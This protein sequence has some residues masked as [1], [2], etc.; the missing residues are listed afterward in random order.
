MVINI[1]WFPWNVMIISES[2][3]VLLKVNG[4]FTGINIK[5]LQRGLWC[6]W[7]STYNA[8][9]TKGVYWPA[10]GQTCY[11]DL[12]DL[13][14]HCLFENVM[15]SQGLKYNAEI[16][17]HALV[18][19][20]SFCK[21]GYFTRVNKQCWSSSMNLWHHCIF[22]NKSISQGLT[23]N[24]EAPQNDFMI[25]L[26]A[27]MVISQG[28]TYNAEAPPTWICWHAGVCPTQYCLGQQRE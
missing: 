14:Y 28:L 19:P 18:I 1:Q 12:Y 2:V 24:A 27:N 3:I 15:I 17:S 23:Y 13:W 8:D 7:N 20:L 10:E 9:L 6:H 21:L 26:F 11:R 16:P 4:Y 22:E 25:S 5:L